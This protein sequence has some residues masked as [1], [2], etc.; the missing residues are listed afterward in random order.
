MSYSSGSL[1]NQLNLKYPTDKTVV[2]TKTARD[3]MMEY[4]K[5]FFFEG[6]F[7]KN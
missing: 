5:Y 7:T 6:I 3:I 1:L 2:I 4:F